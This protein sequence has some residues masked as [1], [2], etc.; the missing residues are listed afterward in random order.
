MT[1]VGQ[2]FFNKMVLHFWMR[3]Y[4]D[5]VELS[6]KHSAKHPSSQ[7]KRAMNS[8]RI[9]C[10]GIAY[11]NLARETE[12]S[13][14]WKKLGEKAVALMS[15]LEFMSKWNFESKLQLLQAE[16]HYVEGD[17]QSAEATYKASILSAHNHK[18]MHE[19]ALACE[20]YGIFCI[21]NQMFEKGCKQLYLALEMYQQWGA[22]RKAKEVQLYIDRVDCS[23]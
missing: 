21:E 16:L 20:L 12:Q 4:K 1:L 19:E 6:E 18:F 23:Y 15:R 7:Q 8:A 13:T 10:E 9:V 14:K 11:L 5:I 2:N 22:I 17:L 3:E